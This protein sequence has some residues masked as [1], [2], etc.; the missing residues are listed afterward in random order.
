LTNFERL[1]IDRGGGGV[2][3]TSPIFKDLK[4]IN[5]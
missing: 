3:L 4:I 2:Q 1:L 5:V